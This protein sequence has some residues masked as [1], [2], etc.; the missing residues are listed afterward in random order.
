VIP[1]TIALYLYGRSFFLE[2]RPVAKEHQEAVNFWLGQ[3][4]YKGTGL[5]LAISRELV[6][7]HGGRIWAESEV[8]A[9][10]AFFF[11]LPLG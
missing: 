6:E 8:G 7:A 11:S 3:A 1:T 2:D 4:N 9:G 5:G 10:S